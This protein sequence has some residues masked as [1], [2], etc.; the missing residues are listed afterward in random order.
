MELFGQQLSSFLQLHFCKTAKR[1]KELAS[2]MPLHF[3]DVEDSREV[4]Y[5]RAVFDQVAN[6]YN[7]LIHLEEA[8]I[9]PDQLEFPFKWHESNSD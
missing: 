8:N 3:I 4:L 2:D 6:L 7:V 5:A 9:T 1:A